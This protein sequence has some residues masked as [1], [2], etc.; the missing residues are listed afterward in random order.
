MFSFSLLIFLVV[1]VVVL[2]KLRSSSTPSS[3]SDI[4]GSAVLPPGPKPVPILGNILDLTPRELWLRATSWAKVYGDITYLHVFGQP[5]VFLNTPRIVF[6]LLDRRGSLYSDK[7]HL[8]MVND[9]CG[10]NDM[11][12]FTGSGAQ[13]KRQRRLMNMALA[14]TRIPTYFPLITRETHCFIRRLLAPKPPTSSQVES[15]KYYIPLLRRYAGQLTLN[16][17][18]GYKV[19]S[20]DDPFLNLAEECVDI[21]S[22]EIA[23][24]GGI[25]P[26]DLIPQLQ[27][28]PEWMPGSGF[29]QKARKWKAKMEEMVDKPYHW[30]KQ[31]VNLNAHTPSFCSTLLEDSD[32]NPNNTSAS[33]EKTFLSNQ[34]E[35]DL[36][37]TANSMYSASLD[38]TITTLQ[39]FFLMMAKYPSAH[40]KARTEIDSII[41]HG[42]R[43]PTFADRSKLPYC[44]ALFSEVL[45]H[46]AG[47][48]MSLPHRLMEDDVFINPTT[49]KETFLKK[50]S[51]IFA[52]IYNITRDPQLWPAPD[53]MPHITPEDFY[54]ERHLLTPAEQ[55]LLSNPS[56]DPEAYQ[57]LKVRRRERDP[58]TYIFGF[59]RRQCPGQNLVSSSA[60]L[61][62][63]TLLATVDWSF[64]DDG[65]G[66]AGRKEEESKVAF[67]NPIFR[68]PTS[69]RL[70]IRPR[71]EAVM[72][73]IGQE[74]NDDQD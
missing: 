47:V 71:S 72:R 19:Q 70:D 37:W 4:T 69:F 56:S 48:P 33:S 65:R 21:L 62:M 13:S 28:M 34:F 68:Q 6:E 23:S 17:V 31:H 25:W 45:R 27:Y 14:G 52:N 64:A 67:E 60:W 20:D 5:L 57:A 11:V 55:T 29:L 24:G 43:L 35:H 73:L 8:T 2:N 63:V 32:F 39:Y 38:T 26:V 66:E 12:A 42:T 9:L 7:P 53:F 58:R 59:G 1:V 54:P 36:K 10:C 51:L 40:A 30:V 16:V 61:V 15:Q 18:Y 50:G 46:N 22:N 74:E 49:G 41:P 44:E 3:K